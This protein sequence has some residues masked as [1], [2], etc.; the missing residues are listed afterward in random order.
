MPVFKLLLLIVGL[1]GLSAPLAAL[2]IGFGRNMEPLEYQELKSD[3]FWL[4]F[5]KRAPQEGR[6]ILNSLE[7]GKPLLE[8]WLAEERKRALPVIMSSTTDHASFANFITDALELQ[9]LADGGR[10]LAWHEL[11]HNIMYRHLS[12]ILGPTGSIVHLPWLPAWWIEGL[13]EMTSRSLGSDWMFGIERYHALTNNWPSYD[14]L[15]SLYRPSFSSIGYSLSGSFV[16]YIVRTYGAD[17]LGQLMRDFYKYSMPWWWP[18]SVVPFADFM[19][20][21]AALR[22]YTGKSGAELYEEYKA[23]ARAYW[24]QA[25]IGPFHH[26]R[27]PHP[28]T[29]DSYEEDDEEEEDM[30]LE[31][32]GLSP[33]FN[34]VYDLDVKGDQVFIISR[35]G[36]KLFETELIFNEKGE[37]K[38]SKGAWQ[39]PS[40]SLVVRASLGPLKVG[41]KRDY[42]NDLERTSHIWLY[43]S[44]LEDHRTVISRPGFIQQLFISRTHLIW[45]ERELEFHRLCQLPL[46]QVLNSKASK[47]KRAVKC[48]LEARY[49]ARLN[50]LGKH[51]Q[52]VEDDRYITDEI[53]LDWNE[54]TLVGNRSKILIWST[55]QGQLRELPNPLGG[56]II[57][58]A[59]NERGFDMLLAGKGRRFIRQ[60]SL[61]GQC[62]RQRKFADLTVNLQTESDGTFIL[63]NWYGNRY[64]IRQ[65]S[66]HFLPEEPCQLSDLP[67]NP[68]QYA[69]ATGDSELQKAL[70][71]SNPWQESK[72]EFKIQYYQA[73]QSA[74]ILHKAAPQAV[75]SLQA[76]EAEWRGRPVFAFPWIG[77]DAKGYQF[78]AISVPLMDHMQN[79]TLR[80]SALYG[81][82]SRF[83][84]TELNFLSNR[85][86]T[87]YG[88]DV[89]RRQAWNG[90]FRG[91]IYYYDE[92]GVKFSAYR[93]F[94]RQRI[95]LRLGLKLSELRPYIG[96][97]EIW[98]RLYKGYHQ[99][100]DFAISKG[101]RLANSY[102][103]YYLFGLV[104]PEEINNNLIYDRL[105]LGIS[106]NIPLRLFGVNSS[107]RY[108]FAYSR[109]RGKQQKLLREVYRPLK[110]FVP[111]SGGGF[112]EINVSLIGPGALTS[113]VYGDNQ[114]RFEF[115]WT[116]PVVRDLETLLHIFYL[117]R[118]DFTAFFNYGRA[119]YGPEIPDL[120]QFVKAHG[121]NLD[122][123]SD[124][125]GVTVNLGLGTGQVIGQDFEIY[126]LFGFDALID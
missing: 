119:W 3:N 68:L 30:I 27:G 32:P 4:Y 20:W 17:K 48:P 69:L 61:D 55:K 10:D 108:A 101:H 9:T 82:E 97:A 111:G 39:L 105:G 81:L 40:D 34:S 107:Q 45:L 2:P 88:I 115:A 54:E 47:L 103:G 114:T 109:T 116:F 36:D 53:Y 44:K 72:H 83:P 89:F 57:S 123:Q 75:Q 91:D 63:S 122:L 7:A 74:A 113:A 11:T 96:P 71:I 99:E 66:P 6:A 43:A 25:D 56:K 98:D 92:R 95:S 104:A 124:I 19:P 110:T 21:D 12:N 79:E 35:I 62:L 16:D 73:L 65:L 78:G 15:H 84:N 8:K 59:R 70:E 37:V 117:E 31:A 13:A 22:N 42:D 67:I 23:A 14:K 1:S 126:F 50:Y 112:N 87:S 77:A 28:V 29:Y 121:Y 100:V 118:L 76:K 26:Y 18:W 80:F 102:L 94:Y 90:S 51:Y 49:P 106:Y 58:L 64:V 86:R 85:F 52:Q 38:A 46:A 93:Y 41:V 5:D 24:L 60:T 33:R 125:K 120:S